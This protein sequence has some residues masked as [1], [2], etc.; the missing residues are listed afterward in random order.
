[1]ARISKKKT[2]EEYTF[3]NGKVD[4]VV[5]ERVWVATD[6]LPAGSKGLTLRDLRDLVGAAITAGVPDNVLVQFQHD[7]G[8]T[9]SCVSVTWTQEVEQP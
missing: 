1:M 7:S 9:T 6:L 5:H 2:D 4:R 3:S 8:R